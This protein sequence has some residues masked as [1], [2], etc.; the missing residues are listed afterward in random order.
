V[1]AFGPETTEVA[2]ADE[3]GRARACMWNPIA[4]ASAGGLGG[5]PTWPRQRF[6]CGVEPALLVGVT[7][8]ADAAWRPRRCLWAHPP[9]RGELVIRFERVALGASIVGHGALD[10]MAERARGG[11]PVELTARVDGEVVGSFI[12]ADG[13]GWARF[14]W[15]LGA[16]AHAPAAEVTFAVSSPDARERGFCFEARSP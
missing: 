11:A 4:R 3:Q 6:E 9:A 10:W 1:A 5:H 15:P 8:I 7:V 12:H 13:D 14:E 16:R 2:L